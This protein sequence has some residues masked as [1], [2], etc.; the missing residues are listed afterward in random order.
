LAVRVSA[1]SRCNK[2]TRQIGRIQPSQ[3]RLTSKTSW[4]T[5]A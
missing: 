2:A 3:E 5:I 4:I 1:H